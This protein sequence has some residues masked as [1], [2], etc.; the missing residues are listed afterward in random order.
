MYNK[1]TLIGRLG[2]DPETRYTAS[3]KAVANFSLAVSEKWTDSG[4][5]KQERTDWFNV[6]AWNKLAE[7]VQ[8]YAHKGDLVLVEGKLQVREY[9]SRDGEK[10]KATEIVAGVFR[11]LSSK[12]SGNGAAGSA[13]GEEGAGDAEH[14]QVTNDDIP[15]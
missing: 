2:R 13:A 4:G 12:R 10:K 1:V 9:E 14:S 15:F 6:V 8:K 7:I 5:E 3:G 11:I